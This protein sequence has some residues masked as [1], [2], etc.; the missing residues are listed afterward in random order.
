MW[1]AEVSLQF[2]TT[3]D[4]GPTTNKDKR[5]NEIGGVGCDDGQIDSNWRQA[6]RRGYAELPSTLRMSV[7][8]VDSGGRNE[9][10]ASPI[11]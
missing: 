7:R 8:Y 1:A 10:G 3:L 9:R 5:P 4:P 11:A 2:V 6:C